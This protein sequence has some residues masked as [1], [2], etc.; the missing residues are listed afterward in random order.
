VIPLLTTL[1]LTIAEITE[2]LE[3]D[4]ALVNQFIANQDN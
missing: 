4:I 1:E 2:V 3:I